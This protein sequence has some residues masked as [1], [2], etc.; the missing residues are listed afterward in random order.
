MNK[1][2]NTTFCSVRESEGEKRGAEEEK[3]KHVK[4]SKS[5]EKQRDIHRGALKHTETN[6][7][8][9]TKRAEGYK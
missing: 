6:P 5:K 7:S 3:H 8:T 2:E 9:I 4:N 1:W